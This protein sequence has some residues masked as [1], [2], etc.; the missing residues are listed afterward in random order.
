M[1]TVYAH[2]ARVAVR[3]G[4]VAELGHHRPATVIRPQQRHVNAADPRQRAEGTH[5]SIMNV[6]TGANHTIEGNSLVNDGTINL[7]GHLRTSLLQ[8]GGSSTAT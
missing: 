1:S 7:N 3:S 2:L 4:N 5:G 8:I 6:E